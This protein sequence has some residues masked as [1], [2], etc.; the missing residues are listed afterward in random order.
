MTGS[1]AVF[2][3]A[4]RFCPV[5]GNIHQTRPKFARGGKSTRNVF[6]CWTTTPCLRFVPLTRNRRRLHNN[7]PAIFNRPTQIGQKTAH[8][9]Q[10]ALRKSSKKAFP[11]FKE[12][13]KHTE[14]KGGI[15]RKDARKKQ[16][17][18]G[19]ILIFQG[20]DT[21][22]GPQNI[23]LHAIYLQK[24]QWKI[25]RERH[26]CPPHCHVCTGISNTRPCSSWPGGWFL[27]SQSLRRFTFG[28]GIRVEQ[29]AAITSVQGRVW[30]GTY[31]E[32]T[33]YSW[34]PR[35]LQLVAECPPRENPNIRPCIR[36]EDHG[37]SGKTCISTA[38][39]LIVWSLANVYFHKTVQ[40]ESPEKNWNWEENSI[41]DC[42]HLTVLHVK[43]YAESAFDREHQNLLICAD[44]TT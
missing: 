6:T 26:K 1:C 35:N 8:S 16:P 40:R 23:S 42:Y 32:A 28:R 13:R 3:Y 15:R 39:Q 29:T 33:E 18:R 21:K 4:S 11:S 30:R 43:R 12:R 25:L 34:N 9:S 20:F 22:Q 27:W 24:L 2:R 31:H 36:E 5:G 17:R 14:E 41:V 37:R 7:S 44:G 19:K 10:D 38:M